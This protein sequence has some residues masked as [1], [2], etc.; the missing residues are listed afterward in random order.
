[1]TGALRR[2]PA[3]D[4]SSTR[5]RYWLSASVIKADEDKTYPGAFVASPASRLA[6]AGARR[7]FLRLAVTGHPNTAETYDLGNGSLSGVDQR[8][9]IDAGFLELTRRGGA[10]GASRWCR[11]V[12]GVPAN[13][14]DVTVMSLQRPRCDVVVVGPGQASLLAGVVVRMGGGE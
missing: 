4:P 10:S 3:C 1:M 9:V 13:D 12:P 5:A 6:A 14:H 8:R 7:Y 11:G 2:P